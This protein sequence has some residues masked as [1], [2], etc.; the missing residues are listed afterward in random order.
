MNQIL[1]EKFL[2]AWVLFI[3]EYEKAGEEKSDPLALV[4]EESRNHIVRAM[5]A[6]HWESEKL[7]LIHTPKLC[8]EIKV[9]LTDPAWH[10][11]APRREALLRG[12]PEPRIPEKVPPQTFQHVYALLRTLGRIVWEEM[13]EIKLVVIKPDKARFFEKDALFGPEVALV[14]P[15]AKTEIKDAGNCLAADLNTAAVFHLMRASEWGLRYLAEH[16]E[17]WPSSK[18]PIEFSQ[19]KDVIGAISIKLDG[20]EKTLVQTTKSSEKF[21]DL[22]RYRGLLA[23]VKFLQITRDGV[24]HTRDIYHNETGAMDVRAKVKSFMQRLASMILGV[25]DPDYQI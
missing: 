16:L 6:M 19:W 14:F 5:E 18:F 3:R 4:D 21:S 22:E 20:K 13:E 23:E 24:M 7:G 9:Q 25:A 12:Q 15:G 2:T 17:A 8:R 10:W 11:D 1:T